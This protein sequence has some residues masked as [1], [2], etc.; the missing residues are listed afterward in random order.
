MKDN[1]KRFDNKL[2]DNKMSFEDCELA[3]LRHA[4]EETEKKQGTEKVNNEDV[5]KIL[6][7]VEDFL[8]KK[9]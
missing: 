1:K 2:C 5:K 8:R 4:V 9:H 3:V 7:I 6:S